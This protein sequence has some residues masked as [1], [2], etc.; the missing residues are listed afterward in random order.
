M[1]LVLE[2]FAEYM[3]RPDSVVTAHLMVVPMISCN[4][5]QFSILK[6]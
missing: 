2:L 6:L 1:D 4:P 5:S 3:V